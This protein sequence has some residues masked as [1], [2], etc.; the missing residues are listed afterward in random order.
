MHALLHMYCL[1]YL[2]QMN[3]LKGMFDLQLAMET[4]GLKVLLTEQPTTMQLASS[5]LDKINRSI[6]KDGMVLEV[7][8]SMSPSLQMGAFWEYAVYVQFSIPPE[9]QTA[10]ILMGNAFAGLTLSRLELISPFTKPDTGLKD[11]SHALS[12][13][14]QNQMNI[15]QSVTDGAM[16]FRIKPDL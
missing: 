12:V 6:G 2:G 4:Y 15:K 1:G 16:F 11:S 5:V 3:K 14:R 9:P 8:C 10:M 13:I 7:G